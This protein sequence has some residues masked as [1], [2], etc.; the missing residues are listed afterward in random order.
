MNE[1]SGRWTMIARA[2][3]LVFCAL[4]A[5][6]SGDGGGDNSGSTCA[7]TVS[8]EPGAPTVIA[9]TTQPF[10]A[11]VA[12]DPNTAVAWSVEE[13]GG[14][15]VS[16]SGVYTAPANLGTYHVVATSQA[17]SCGTEAATVTVVAAPVI[18]VSISPANSVTLQPGG[19][20]A[21]VATVTGT[22]NTGVIWTAQGTAGGS[23]N[24]DGVYTM[25]LNAAN[26]ATDQVIATSVV[27]PTKSAQVLVVVSVAQPIVI[28]PTAATVALGGHVDFELSAQTGSG[29]WSVNDI[30]FGNSDVGTIDALGVY[31]APYQMPT[32]T[33]AA[34][35][36]TNTTDPAN[37]A[38]VTWASRFLSPETLQ[39]DDCNPQCAVDIPNAIVA[40]DFNDDGFSDLATANSGT[41]TIS[42]LISSDE[43]HFA[44]P[45]RLDVGATNSGDPQALA[46]ADL[47]ED[48][49]AQDPRVDL[50]LADADLGG[51]AVRSRLGNDDGTFGNEVGT[52]LPTN[53]NPLSMAVGDFDFDGHV[54][55]AV[56]NFVTNSIDVLLGVGDGSFQVVNT[57]TTGVSA[58]LGIVAADFNRDNYAD[59]AVANNGSDTVL[60]LLGI[61]DGTFVLQPVQLVANSHP[62][63]VAAVTVP[64][65]LNM[66]NFPD[67]VVTTT[68]SAL[69]GGLT[70]IF[71]AGI[72]LAQFDPRFLAPEPPIATGSLPVALAIGNFNRDSVPDVVVANQGDDSLKIYLFDPAND[73]LVLSETYAVG[74][75]PQGLAVGDFNGDGWDDVAVTNSDD[76]TV[77]VLRNRGGPTP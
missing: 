60:V 38:T 15:T 8:I 72:G 29:G 30:A 74:D 24:V 49:T 6:C 58:P 63:A 19:S 35:R 61:G 50:V 9:N 67:L 3:A 27:D 18:E 51:L 33:T 54:D 39:V 26:S 5:A 16:S 4:L 77:S 32:S 71:N 13:A 73:E 56:A 21:F 36:N 34:I 46:T 12:G 1:S 17:D 7:V 76:D 66:D 28:S 11:T 48:G 65:T 14:G 62:T 20:Q 70:V 44:D 75:R 23:I 53:S 55:V 40:A 2:G 41:G 37:S 25:P 42:L 69:N 22:A 59:L 43:S 45:Y 64:G 47:N 10:A 31:T 68:T 57:I 52:V